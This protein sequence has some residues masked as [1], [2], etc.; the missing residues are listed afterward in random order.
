MKA[1][2]VETPETPEEVVISIHAAREGGDGLLVALNRQPCVISIHAA[3]EGGDLLLKQQNNR[4]S[5]FN[6]R[7]P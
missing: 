4:N 6:P 5:H 1:A 2:T 3:R 7:R